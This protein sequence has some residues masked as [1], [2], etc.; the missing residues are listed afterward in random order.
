[1]GASRSESD[2]KALAWK[3]RLKESKGKSSTSSGDGSKRAAYLALANMGEIDDLRARGVEIEDSY[4]ALLA[5]RNR[6]HK[7]DAAAGKKRHD[8][9]A[10]QENKKPSRRALFGGLA[11]AAVGIVLTLFMNGFFG[12]SSMHTITGRLWF[13]RRP[14]SDV[15]LRFHIP[16]AGGDGPS[17]VTTADGKFEIAGL[18]SGYYLVTLHPT[19]ESSLVVP[20]AY[21]QPES[22]LF[23]LNV[24]RDV[25]NMQ[26]Y[27]Y[28][29]PPQP[30]KQTWVPGVD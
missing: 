23:K 1:M 28:R 5:S 12:S 9:R 17:V 20:P 22:A 16:G 7:A 6:S 30:R 8:Q 26:L 18:P 3:P 19:G 2:I 14:A 11:G 15:E 21:T 4:V 29:K 10:S 25:N 27:A 24:N 13:E